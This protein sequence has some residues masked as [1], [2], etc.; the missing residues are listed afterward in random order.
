M[1]TIICA[2]A[3]LGYPYLAQLK[4]LLSGKALSISSHNALVDMYNEGLLQNATTKAESSGVVLTAQSHG[5]L[6]ADGF[7]ILQEVD[8]VYKMVLDIR[9]R[10][11]T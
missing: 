4:H 5:G 3:L 11:K 2:Q 7:E 10:W 6:A 9:A 1:T 8:N